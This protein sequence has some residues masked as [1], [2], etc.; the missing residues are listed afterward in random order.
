MEY[1]KLIEWLAN[2]EHEQWIHWTTY[3]IRNYNLE[4]VKRWNKQALKIY[5]QLSEE[6]KEKDREWAEKIID[7][8]PFKCPI[9][10]CG[11]IMKAVERK[12]PKGKNEDDFPD[13]MVG[14][15]QTPD[16]VCSNCKAIYSFN[17]FKIKK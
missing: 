8:M 15:F 6:D 1:K 3:F 14:D 16:L 13:G 17:K 7:E 12:Y 10:Q 5:S 4:N 9:W 2:K 11:G